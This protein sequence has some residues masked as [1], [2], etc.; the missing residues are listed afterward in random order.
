MAESNVVG[1]GGGEDDMMVNVF[2]SMC[3]KLS[4]EMVI[5]LKHARKVLFAPSRGHGAARLTGK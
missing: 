1:G 4:N 2:D 3:N 5:L